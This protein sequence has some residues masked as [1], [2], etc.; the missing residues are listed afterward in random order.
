MD[1]TDVTDADRADARALAASDPLFRD[2][3]RH[4]LRLEAAVSAAPG[5]GR[6]AVAALTTAGRRPSVSSTE[7]A[8]A[9]Q[10]AAAHATATSASARAADASVMVVG[11]RVVGHGPAPGPVQPPPV[12]FAGYDAAVYA[13]KAARAAAP[14]YHAGAGIAMGAAHAAPA[15]HVPS[16]RVSVAQQ[17]PAGT[18][19]NARAPTAAVPVTIPAA[20]AA[21]AAGMAVHRRVSVLPASPAA[22]APPATA[23]SSGTAPVA[24]SPPMPPATAAV[25]GAAMLLPLRA[26]AVVAAGPAS[27]DTSGTVAHGS[28]SAQSAPPASARTSPRESQHQV[29]SPVLTAILALLPLLDRGE[30]KVVHAALRAATSAVMPFPVSL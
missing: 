19:G 6:D 29:S 12:P 16:A 22:A 13:A 18:A 28:A 10:L 14:S 25:V 7:S 21:P 2:L 3:L 8:G 9:S 26:A 23:A 17:S 11:G 15:G 27:P 5:S 20:S 4:A 30:L 24:M 1:Q